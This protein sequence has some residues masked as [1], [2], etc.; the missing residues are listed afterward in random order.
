VPALLEP[1]FGAGWR[2]EEIRE[3]AADPPTLF[4]FRAVTT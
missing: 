3:N 4:G 1:V 2:V